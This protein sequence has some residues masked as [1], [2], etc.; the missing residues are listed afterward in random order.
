MLCYCKWGV[1]MLARTATDQ[2]AEAIVLCN[3]NVE[4]AG[5]RACLPIYAAGWLK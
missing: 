4:R 2:I 3:G 1:A 5:D